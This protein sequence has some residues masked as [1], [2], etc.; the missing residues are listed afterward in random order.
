MPSTEELIAQH[1]EETVKKAFWLQEQIYEN[2]IEG[3][4]YTDE[5]E[6]RMELRKKPLVKKEIE[7]NL[8]RKL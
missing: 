7:K 8:L 4:H 1:G 5:A 2:G 6:R 3:I